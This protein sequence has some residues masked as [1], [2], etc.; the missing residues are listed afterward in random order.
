[1]QGLQHTLMENGKVIG[2]LLV[3]VAIGRILLTTAFTI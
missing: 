1:M 2:I 3:F